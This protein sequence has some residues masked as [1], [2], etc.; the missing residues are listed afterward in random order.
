MNM[1]QLRL[2]W[3]ELHG[4]D[5]DTMWSPPIQM[6]CDNKGAIALV[7]PEKRLKGSK[8]CKT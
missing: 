6:Y 2:L 8:A 1:S 7:K 4:P 5:P 3:N